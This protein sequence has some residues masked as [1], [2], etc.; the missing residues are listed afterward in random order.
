M[1]EEFCLSDKIDTIAY[2]HYQDDYISLENV[3]EFIKR[4][5]E[6]NNGWDD[7]QVKKIMNEEIDKLAGEKLV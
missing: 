7:E 5:K 4:L 2:S 6:F 1:S 3:R